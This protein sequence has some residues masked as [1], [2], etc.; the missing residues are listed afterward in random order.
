MNV[1]LSLVVVAAITYIHG[2]GDKGK[3]ILKHQ[4]IFIIRFLDSLDHVTFFFALNWGCVD[5]PKGYGG[6][7]CSKYGNE[8]CHDKKTNNWSKKFQ[9]ACK[10]TCSRYAAAYCDTIICKG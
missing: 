8:Y 9:A 10:D 1:A 6:Y 5:D 2:D 4:N 3:H 7:D